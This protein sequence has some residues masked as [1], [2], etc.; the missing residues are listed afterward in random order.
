M[1]ADD[2]RRDARSFG[3]EPLREAISD[4]SDVIPRT[5]SNDFRFSTATLAT[6]KAVLTDSFGTILEYNRTA[7]H[8]AR[9]GIDHYQIA[10]CMQGRMQFS[11]GRRELTMHPGDIWLVDMAEPSRTWL[12]QSDER[13][14][15]VMALVLPRATLAPLLAHPDSMTGSFISARE[16]HAPLVAS[17][18]TAL[19]HPDAQ[20][21]AD[22]TAT[23][24]AMTD[25]V[26]AAFG[27]AAE[28][29]GQIGRAERHLQLAMIRRYIETNLERGLLSPDHLCS[30][31]GISRASLYR[32]FEIDGGLQRYVQQQRLNRALRRLIYPAPP[33]NRVIDLASEL[34][35]SS[36]SSFI[37]AFRRQF[38]LTPGE[39][40]GLS[41]AWL[42]ETAAVA[43]PDSLFHHLAGRRPTLN[44]F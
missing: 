23:I 29:K 3:L 11:A 25:V 34:Q 13:Q 10:F 33:G 37:R 38:G 2:F 24:Q 26:A 15:R 17:Q 18:F 36:E 31:F 7:A 39:V 41:S 35:F 43:G 12:G 6:D 16:Q 1:R 19:W 4:L 44:D 20:D 5:D 8:I 42:R 40:K 30:R 32:L 22:L 28:V 21:T 9:G 14:V 27:G